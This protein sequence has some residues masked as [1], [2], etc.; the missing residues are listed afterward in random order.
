MCP[1]V[2]LAKASKSIDLSRRSSEFVTH[3]ERARPRSRTKGGWH[4]CPKSAG[5]LRVRARICWPPR[6]VLV[7]VRRALG[8]PKVAGTFLEKVPATFVRL[9]EARKNLQYKE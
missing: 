6:V 8:R 1:L 5:H 9:H 7:P 4:L 2:E 3:R